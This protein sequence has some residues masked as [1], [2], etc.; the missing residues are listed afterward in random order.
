MKNLLHIASS[1]Q[2]WYL[3]H[4]SLV[5]VIQNLPRIKPQHASTIRHLTM[6]KTFGM[7]GVFTDHMVLQRGRVNYHLGRCP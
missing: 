2:A 6:A 5:A 1:S 3:L 4:R 7:A